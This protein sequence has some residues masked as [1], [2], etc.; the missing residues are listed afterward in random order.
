MVRIKVDKMG[1]GGCAETVTRAILRIEP[2][3][4]IDVD[5]KAKL[6]MVSGAG[7]PAD[8]IAQAITAAG[9]PAEPV[10]AAA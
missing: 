6:V 4:R 1:C 7:D 2:G 3:A 10:L 5:L 8:H 9:Y